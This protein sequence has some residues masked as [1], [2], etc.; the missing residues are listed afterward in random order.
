VEQRVLEP[1]VLA[2]AGGLVV[3][4]VAPPEIV[5]SGFAA[6]GFLIAL[7]AIATAATASSRPSSR[8]VFAA[9]PVALAAG[10]MG[11]APGEAVEPVV[12]MLLAATAGIAAAASSRRDET[13]ARLFAVLVAFVGGRALYETI[14]GLPSWAARVRESAPTTTDGLALLTRLEQGRP[15]GGFLT[16]A[17]L[18]CFLILAVPPVA[19]WAIGKRGKLRALGLSAAVLGAAALAATR[20]LSALGALAGAIALC[21]LRGRVRPR[22]VAAAAAAIGLVILCVG[23]LR[24][25]AVFSPAAG[26]SPWRLRGGNV[27]I[28]LQIAR[29]H[30]LAGVGPGGYAEAFPQYRR[31]GDN[32]SRH[33][34]NLPS[35]LAADWGVPIGLALSA[36]FFLAFAGPLFRWSGD[37]KTFGFGLSV[38]LS[39]FAL[40]NLA[41]FTAFLPSLLV[42][43][44]VS[45]GLLAQYVPPE[46]AHHGL[47]AAWI[48]VASGLALLAAGSGLA[49]DAL[50]DAKQAGAAGA[51]AAAVRLAKRATRLAPWDADPPQVAAFARLAVGGDLAGALADAD[52]AVTRAPSRAAARVVRARARGAGGDGAGAF[53][54]LAEAARLYPMSSDYALQR[55]SLAEALGKAREGAPR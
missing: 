39:A 26:D 40:H 55:D 34:H 47:R 43:A 45:R 15:Y 7:A 4:V 36:V 31:S 48:T 28:A 32:E 35:E 53:A 46:R 8:W 22:V 49:R 21:G 23:L 13:I 9:I 54:D 17:A 38:G 50:F 52:R 25:D 20:S 11:I 1:A 14:W 33:A 24:A 16:P 37:A 30:P 2:L 5:G 3:C 19:M 42:F 10:R 12:T 6:L 27:R 44:A 18:G 29:E 51:H 41:D